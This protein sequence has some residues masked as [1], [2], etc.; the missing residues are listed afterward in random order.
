MVLELI[1]IIVILSVLLIS[2]I[3]NSIVKESELKTLRKYLDIIIDLEE[4]IKINKSEI[5]SIKKNLKNHI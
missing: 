2:S 5:E 3:I 1:V 4:R